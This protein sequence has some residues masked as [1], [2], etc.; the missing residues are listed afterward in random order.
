ML[1]AVEEPPASESNDVASPKQPCRSMP[2]RG[3]AYQ[4][5]ATLRVSCEKKIRVRKER[6]IL[7]DCH[8]ASDVMR[9]PYRTRKIGGVRFSRGCSPGWYVAAPLGRRE[10]C[11]TIFRRIKNP[12]PS[13]PSMPPD[14][15]RLA[16]AWEARATA[17]NGAFGTCS[18]RW[19]NHRHRKA[20][21]LHHQSSLAGQCPNGATH[22]SPEQ[23]SG[24]PPKR[25]YAF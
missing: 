5:G 18:E 25:R 7:V 22:T 10:P 16:G 21:M 20:T 24:Y 8:S 13:R 9:R 14:P 15:G 11:Q 6:R 1:R 4:P 2:H 19:R 3:H 12:E 17:G 23:R